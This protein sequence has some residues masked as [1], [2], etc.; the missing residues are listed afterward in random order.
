M[1]VFFHFSLNHKRKRISHQERIVTVKFDVSER[2]NRTHTA[3]TRTFICSRVLLYS[4]F[5]A[6]ST[7]GSAAAPPPSSAAASP[8]CTGGTRSGTSSSVPLPPHRSDDSAIAA[9]TQPPRPQPSCARPRGMCASPATPPAHAAPRARG[10]SRWRAVARHGRRCAQTVRRQRPAPLPKSRATCPPG[11][12]PA[13]CG[14]T[15]SRRSGQGARCGAGWRWTRTHSPPPSAARGSGRT[16][17][18]CGSTPPS[19]SR[20]RN[21]TPSAS[22]QRWRGPQQPEDCACVR[23]RGSHRS[24]A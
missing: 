12:P 19:R 9:Q 24:T 22:P 21:R 7:N 15:G 17:C 13:A 23:S 20:G 14:R 8:C 5:N 4:R 18:S 3:H 11:C 1:F 16:G 10:P 6:S 2:T